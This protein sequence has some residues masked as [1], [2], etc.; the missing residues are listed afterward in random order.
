MS[1]N[2]ALC[3]ALTDALRAAAE[4]PAVHVIVACS[5]RRCQWQRNWPSVYSL[6][7][8]VASK[9]VIAEAWMEFVQS[10]RSRENEAFDVLLASPESRAAAAA[11]VDRRVG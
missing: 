6:A 11:F 7:S 5:T 1:F 3:G 8:L 4:R 10:P 9:R 2:Q